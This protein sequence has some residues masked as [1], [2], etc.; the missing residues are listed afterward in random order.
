MELLKF[1]IEAKRAT[2]AAQGD[3]ASVSPLLDGS[4]Q[5]EY[6]N[7]DY[8]YRDIYF[9]MSFF[10][11]QET[12]YYKNEPVWSMVYSGGVIS[13]DFDSAET[14]RVYSFL[15]NAMRR[16]TPESPYRGPNDFAEGD[17]VYVNRS[18]G[19]IHRFQGHETITLLD[20]EVYSLDY[21]GG[22]LT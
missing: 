7:G 19:G 8:F 1:L 11:G 10:V 13:D 2:Y 5:L 18:N 15:R 6:C 12:V 21:S 3:D 22:F 20:R 17:F 4:R 9:G 16:I 14:R